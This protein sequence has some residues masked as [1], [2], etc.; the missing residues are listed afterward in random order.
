MNDFGS[1]S[2][3]TTSGAHF[4]PA[5]SESGIRTGRRLLFRQRGVEPA[6][7]ARDGLRGEDG[8]DWSGPGEAM[9]AAPPI[10]TRVRT[11]V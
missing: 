6:P 1:F 11:H 8:Y 2:P 7:I 9:T 10:E 3:E 4:K 5:G